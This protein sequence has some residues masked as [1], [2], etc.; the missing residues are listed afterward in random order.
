MVL[1]IVA[2]ARHLSLQVALA[3]GLNPATMHGVRVITHPRDLRFTRAGTPFLELPRTG[4]EG[5]GAGRDLAQA[6]DRAMRV[7]RLRVAQDDDVEAAR[8]G[9]ASAAAEGEKLKG[10]TRNPGPCE[11]GTEMPIRD[12]SREDASRH[13]SRLKAGMTNGGGVA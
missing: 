1:Y 13:G 3:A 8:K 5:T 11:G 10:G 7:G 4:W 9:P 12:P 2:P 6:V